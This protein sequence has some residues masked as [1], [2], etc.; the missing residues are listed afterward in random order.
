MD[1][2]VEYRQI[3]KAKRNIEQYILHNKYMC[4]R[5]NR[6]YVKTYNELVKNLEYIEKEVRKEIELV[7]DDFIK[8]IM[9][10]HYI[11]G[12]TWEN[13]AYELGFTYTADNIRKTVK[14]YRQNCKKRKS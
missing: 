3:L 2:I 1:K 6:I 8:R 12:L 11:D 5:L 14:R 13:I 10:N 7:E 9:I 4:P